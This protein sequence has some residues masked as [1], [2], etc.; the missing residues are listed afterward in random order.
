M[1]IFFFYISP[2]Y[3][4]IPELPQPV[5]APV[6]EWCY[7]D[8]LTL[9]HNVTGYSGYPHT[10]EYG[11]YVTVWYP[12]PGFNEV[13][14]QIVYSLSSYY[15]EDPTR[16]E[17]CS[18]TNIFSAAS[19]T[20]YQFMNQYFHLYANLD[21]NKE[22]IVHLILDGIGVQNQNLSQ[23]ERTFLT[24]SY[25]QVASAVTVW[26]PPYLP[27]QEIV[28]WEDLGTTYYE[29]INFIPGSIVPVSS[30][31]V[32]IGIR[33]RFSSASETSPNSQVLNLV[34]KP[35]PPSFNMS[36]SASCP[37]YASGNI[38]LSGISSFTGITDY[39]L[40]V[41]KDN[42]SS[43]NYISFSGSNY[44][45]GNLRSGNYKLYLYYENSDLGGCTLDN[46]ATFVGEYNNLT[47][48]VNKLTDA[49]CPGLADGK[50]GAII[51]TYQGDFR[52][53]LGTTYL[54]TNTNGNFESLPA[55]SY[56]V[57][58]TDM[59]HSDPVGG[60]AVTISQPSPVTITSINKINPT[61]NSA[62]NGSIKVNASG[63]TAGNTSFFYQFF[64]DGSLLKSETGN[65]E[66]NYS[67]LA[68]GNYT[69]N[70]SAGGCSPT[71]TPTQSLSHV[72]PINFSYV[73]T[74]VDCFG[75]NTGSIDIAA[76][77]GIA[78]YQYSINGGPFK[79]GSKFNGLTTGSYLVTV[80][81]GASGCNGDLKQG[82]V[83]VGTAPKIDIS[84]IE[85][86]NPSCFE[87]EDGRIVAGVTGGIGGYDYS[88]TSNVKYIPDNS[89]I[90]TAL[91]A[92]DYSLSVTDSRNCIVSRG[93]SLSEPP[94]LIVQSAAPA[95]AACFGGQGSILVQASGGTP[96]YQYS[97]L[98]NSGFGSSSKLSVPA[99]DY[100]VY[101]K[102]ANGC[103]AAYEDIISIT[104]PYT[105][106][107][108]TFSSPSYN[109]FSI[110]CAGEASGSIIV[111]ASGGNGLKYDGS[112]YEGYVYSA[113]G[114]ADQLS[115]S[116]SSLYAGNKII[117][118]T[119]GRGCSVLKNVTL[120]QPDPLSVN[121]V[122]SSPVRCFGAATG[123]IVVSATGGI[124][125]TYKYRFDEAESLSPG[126][127][128][129]LLADTYE[130]EVSDLNGCRRNLFATVQSIN[131]PIVIAATSKDVRCFGEVNGEITTLVTG[132]AG[133]F[134]FGWEK[135]S[136]DDWLALEGLTGS[137]T[138]LGPGTYRVKATDSEECFEYESIGIG[139]PSL[140]QVT[141]A[142]A[143][144]IVCFGEK[145]TI[146]ITAAGGN[147]G[148]T[149]ICSAAN[150]DKFEGS[151]PDLELPAGSYSA[152][153]RDAKGCIAIHPPSLVITEPASPL[154]FNATL[155]SYNGY[156]VSCNGKSD[157]QIT[158]DATGGNSAGYT[159][160]TYTLM[161]GSPQAENTFTGLA[162][163]SYNVKVADARGCS[164]QKNFTLTQP[165]LLSMNLQRISPVKCFGA[166]TGEI[167]VTSAGGAPGYTYKLNGTP[168]A[169]SGVFSGL[170]AGEYTVETNDMNGCSSSLDAYV[171][172]KNPAIKL[173]L[174]TV[175]VKCYGE[176]NGEISAEI[177]G[178]SG[179]FSN[180]WENKTEAGWLAYQEGGTH[181]GS[182]KAGEYRLRTID[183]DNC[184][185][186]GIAE[187]IEPDPLIISKVSIKDAVCF[188]DQGSIE[189][190]ASGGNEG[191]WFLYSPNN[192]RIVFHNYSPPDPLPAGVYGLKV[193]DS[194][195]CSYEDPRAFYI[196][197]PP[198]ALEFNTILSEYSGF[199]V[200]CYGNNDG[201]ITVQASGGNGSGY[202]GYSYALP[203]GIAKDENVF[204]GLEA[205]AY[206]ITVTD[207]RGCRLTKQVTLVQPV[208]EISLKSSAI[209][210]PVCAYDTDGAITLTALGGSMPYKYS[211]NNGEYTPSSMFT[212]LGVNN[213]S[214]RVK[215]IN[216]CAQ[217]FD[218]SLVNIIS[219]MTLSGDVTDVRCFGE[220]TGSVTAH[221][222]GGAYPYSWSWKGGY[223]TTPSVAN[224][225]R[226][227]YSVTVIDS[228]GCKAEKMFSV[229]QPE[230]PL[231]LTAAASPACVNLKDGLISTVTTGGTPPYRYAAD[232]DK[233]F[234]LPASFNVYS[235]SHKVFARDNN[236]CIAETQVFVNVKNVMPDINFMLAT[237]R[238]EL[239]TLVVI[240]VSVP[241]PDRVTWEFSTDAAVIDT[242]KNKA[243]VRY[244]Q[245]GLFPVK[246]TGLF[247]SCAYTIEKLL[248][249]APFDP[250]TVSNDKDKTGIKTLKISPNPN[251]GSF[252][253]RVELYTRQQVT[254]AVYDI[255]SRIV[256]HEKLPADILFVEEVNLPENVM[257]GTY[258]LRVTAEN[259][260]R[261]A[262]FVISE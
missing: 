244:N 156:S 132:G 47:F 80:L 166:S 230:K 49:S 175:P 36:A 136:G 40:I 86:K 84:F 182:L 152:G 202:S 236:C 53:S 191:Y 168:A 211:I 77:G 21:Q 122:S 153:I 262:V 116:F 232:T 130:I 92:G 48:T 208:S 37:N 101:V 257:P 159:G 108:F 44:T 18:M 196:T 5:I 63:G 256:Y 261:S 163:G 99:G 250:S 115:P 17:E 98:E 112:E 107:D 162:A 135:K 220:S 145:G 254:V 161:T 178:G 205:G 89:N 38:S 91:K 224:L 67:G 82:Y 138:N 150:G 155:S 9:S 94:D 241:P 70:V 20:D 65:Q 105:P 45:V 52:F 258:I 10:W 184:E 93:T 131:P 139:E 28:D 109:G 106:L 187:V 29:S 151:Q 167:E 143:A 252:E 125:N 192:G 188:G 32:S 148:F 1:I 35:R 144:D 147:A 114:S 54:P 146:A 201:R 154:G 119:D 160:Y 79:T 245:A 27:N 104:G 12:K 199:N 186:A 190:D 96:G 121:L 71:S 206:D 234:T 34:I 124:V 110:A 231:S 142:T 6:S 75:S 88:W 4:T 113:A 215:D 59:C 235:G 219:M 129:D 200:S 222:K 30:G 218:T 216:G 24:T 240:D 134:S 126:I 83:P 39:E 176:S 213:Y 22:A 66:V 209:K 62:P 223:S 60:D 243:F 189:I 33:V 247:G 141:S 203:D 248:N 239:D 97:Y 85:L 157:A 260:A 137:K 228:A 193:M 198:V 128:K 61:C 7:D 181:L 180:V 117:K 197:A 255:Y 217:T 229:S 72:Q 95:D 227:S 19:N 225:L 123:E 26:I 120:T 177:T 90:I 11:F 68:G 43:G 16:C 50:I 81:T 100:N 226:G 13:I 253:L 58:A 8:N 56:T 185:A 165:D 74:A 3:G 55:G 127:F 251:D 76:S 51:K 221:V 246:M 158:I 242:G 174:S 210:R 173:Q 238:Y 14:D 259:D 194:K 42:E 249:I 171:E 237:S 195:G 69:I 133:G 64:K 212:G 204:S 78:P 57:K 179:G 169:S 23:N 214:F 2:L 233:D 183:S 31:K 170:P 118:V 140:L 46:Q 164:I 15:S 103:K 73:S 111:E 25:S 102:D 41:K 87:K 172:H 207:G 149:Y